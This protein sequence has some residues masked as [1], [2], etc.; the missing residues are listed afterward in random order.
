MITE[1]MFI[2][3]MTTYLEQVYKEDPKRQIIFFQFYDG[4]PERVLSNA[5]ND[6]CALAGIEFVTLCQSNDISKEEA[7]D[8][9]SK[10]YD[11][12]VNSD[13]T[14]EDRSDL[15]DEIREPNFEA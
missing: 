2:K 11:F 14:T 10:A 8:Y 7:L 4:E 6:I 15:L 13:I 9:L 3:F 12:V 5:G 1:E